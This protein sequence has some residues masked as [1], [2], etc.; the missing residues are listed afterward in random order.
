MIKMNSLN[1]RMIIR[2]RKL[3]QLPDDIINVDFLCI[4][5]HILMIFCWLVIKADDFIPYLIL[6]FIQIVV[7]R[8]PNSSWFQ[9]MKKSVKIF[10]FCLIGY[11]PKTCVTFVQWLL[12]KLL[13]FC[14]KKQNW[15]RSS[16]FI[17]SI[18]NFSQK[19]TGQ[20][21]NRFTLF[22]SENP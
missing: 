16:S 14:V 10:G 15:L 5:H 19:K 3:R 8:V 1:K 11:L 17:A 13:S 4:I 7:S 9:L 6:V 22:F 18:Q 20:D 12:W 2:G 21:D